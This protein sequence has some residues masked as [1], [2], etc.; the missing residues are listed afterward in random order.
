MS[1]GQRALT[2]STLATSRV[3]PQRQPSGTCTAVLHGCGQDELG[4]CALVKQSAAN[5]AEYFRSRFPSKLSSL[6]IRLP[7]PWMTQK[8]RGIRSCTGSSLCLEYGVHGT[9]VVANYLPEGV[10][11]GPHGNSV[12]GPGGP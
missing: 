4:D 3:G 10:R 7:R 5:I 6:L 8:K 11:H 12:G 9:S 1:Y 2:V